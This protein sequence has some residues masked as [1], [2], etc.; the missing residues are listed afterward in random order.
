MFK[1]N[2]YYGQSSEPGPPDPILVFL[3]TN[4][5]PWMVAVALFLC[6]NWITYRVFVNDK[7]RA[8]EGG[9]RISERAL[10]RLAF[11]GGSPAM[12]VARK[13]HRHKTKKQPF[14]RKFFGIIWLQI[15]CILGVVYLV[16]FGATIPQP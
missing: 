1:K 6:I 14:V 11:F 16:H 10:L 3:E 15:V 7:R 5:A 12:W 13:R 9:Q 4:V 2:P 8:I